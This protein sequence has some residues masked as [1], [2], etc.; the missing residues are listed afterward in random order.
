MPGRGRLGRVPSLLW[1]L[2]VGMVMGKERKEV[3]RRKE[4]KGGL[5]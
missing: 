3:R 4:G 1:I 2:G 5:S